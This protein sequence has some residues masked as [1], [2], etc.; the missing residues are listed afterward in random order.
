MDAPSFARYGAVGKQRA[1]G[2]I[3]NNQ[4]AESTLRSEK[5]HM[6]RRVTLGAGYV[7]AKDPDGPTSDYEQ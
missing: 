3:G 5:S 4:I 6:R 7:P 2:N 1:S